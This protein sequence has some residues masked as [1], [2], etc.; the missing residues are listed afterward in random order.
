MSTSDF[1]DSDESNDI[2]L[3]E[4]ITQ[5]NRLK[6]VYQLQHDNDDLFKFKFM[7]LFENLPIVNLG[8][9]NIEGVHYYLTSHFSFL[10]NIDNNN[11]FDMINLNINKNGKLS[12]LTVGI[13]FTNK[14]DIDNLNRGMAY[15]RYVD[16]E[17][18]INEVVKKNLIFP[19]STKI[20]YFLVRELKNDKIQ[21]YINE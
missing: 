9:F 18:N 3:E 1:S 13:E 11:M 7:G 14:I 10:E 8:D 19:G 4:K 2:D 17:K 6:K 20:L 5:N 12:Y 15:L 16:N 21:S